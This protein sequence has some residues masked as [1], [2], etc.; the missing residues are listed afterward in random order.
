MEIAFIIDWQVE[1]SVKSLF[2]TLA[3]HEFNFVS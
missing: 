1:L 3:V 2:G